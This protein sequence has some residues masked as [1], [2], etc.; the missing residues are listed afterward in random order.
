MPV[1]VLSPRLSSYWVAL[2]T[3]VEPALVAPARRRPERGDCSCARPPPAGINDDPLGFDD[4]VRA[5]LGTRASTIV[6]SMRRLLTPLAV[7]IAAY[8]VVS[9]VV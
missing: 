7:L 1:P 9:R 8:A 4:A 2:V 6:A 3:P 5:A